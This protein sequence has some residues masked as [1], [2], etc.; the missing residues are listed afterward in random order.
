MRKFKTPRTPKPKPKKHQIRIN[1]S[2]G[3]KFE[4]KIFQYLTEHLRNKNIQGIVYKV[5]EG[6]GINQWIDILIDSSE[7][8]YVG[9]E[10]KSINDDGLINDKIYLKVLSRKNDDYGHQFRKQHF[11]L[12]SSG[13]FGVI[14]FEFTSRKLVILVSHQYI[15]EKI[16]A[17]EVYITVDEIVKKG[18]NIEDKEASLKMFIRR[19][20]KTKTDV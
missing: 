9:I 6:K 1:K 10:C 14:A 13:R 2:Q 17:G 18:F 4:N 11:F 19:H 15:Y 7:F 12:S 20:C 16:E 3:T 8:G 5:P